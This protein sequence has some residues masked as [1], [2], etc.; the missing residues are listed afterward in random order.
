[1]RFKFA[2]PLLFAVLA[3]QLGAGGASAESAAAAA[4]PAQAP[5]GG[6]IARV[7]RVVTVDEEGTPA[8]GTQKAREEADAGEAGPCY[9]FVWDVPSAVRHRVCRRLIHENRCVRARCCAA[10]RRR[11]GMNG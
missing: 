3:Q 8:A 1:M 6:L 10:R 11:R 5:S 4:P 7:K 2:A 9:V